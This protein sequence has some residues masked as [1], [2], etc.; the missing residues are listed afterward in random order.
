MSFRP[1]IVLAPPRSFSSVV[2]GMLGQHPQTYGFPELNLF[3]ADTV[4]ETLRA[5]RF[6]GDQARH[7]LLR[8][9]AQ[10][11]E[12]EQTEEGIRQAEQWLIDHG[13]WRTEELFDYLLD[14]VAPRVGIDK[15]PRT[16]MKAEYL[17]R[18]F[19]CFPDAFYLHLVRHPRTTG[20]SQ[21]KITKRNAEWGGRL[22]ASR[23]NPDRWWL[24]AQ[25]SILQLQRR[26]REDQMMVIRGEDLLSAPHTY[27]PQI[28]EWLSLRTDG[29]AIECMLHPERSPYACVGPENAK[30]GNDINF[31]EKP[32]FRPGTVQEACLEGPLAWAP[33]RELSEETKRISRD[34]G[35]R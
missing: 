34:Y 8:T 26:M 15:S 30:Y 13:H 19:R 29:D 22:N 35:Y 21:I 9:L 1:L 2:V 31:L 24:K 28:A 25:S 6:A 16:V 33:D 4:R 27:L 7:G 32:S 5:Y 10:L 23:I 20:A 11:H 12:G 18:M 14:S 3:V 17:D